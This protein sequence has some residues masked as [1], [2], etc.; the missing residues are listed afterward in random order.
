MTEE[1]TG[2]PPADEDEIPTGLPGDAES[3]PLGVPE[4]DP[5]GEGDTP[6]GDDAM[7]GIPTQGEPPTAG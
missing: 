4:A 2:R 6:R 3:D 1:H 5:E 7:P